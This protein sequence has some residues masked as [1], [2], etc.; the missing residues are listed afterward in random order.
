MSLDFVSMISQ[1]S[2]YGILK[3]SIKGD[4]IEINYTDSAKD[5]LKILS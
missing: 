5:L 4:S 3:L 2:E 1:K